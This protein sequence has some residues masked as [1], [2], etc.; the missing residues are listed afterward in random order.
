MKMLITKEVVE[1]YD[2]H[3]VSLT[4]KILEIGKY[5]GALLPKDLEE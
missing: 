2:G 1:G 5:K 3:E 4:I